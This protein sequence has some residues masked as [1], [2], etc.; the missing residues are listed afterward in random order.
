MRNKEYTEI[1]GKKAQFYIISAVIIIF[2]IISLAVVTNYVTVRKEPTRFYNLADILKTE[3]I[4]VV[5]YSEYNRA[6]GTV[7]EN[8]DR[9]LEIFSAYIETHT[10]EDF[11]LVIL[12]GNASGGEVLGRVIQRT[13]EGGVTVSIGGGAP[14][15]ITQDASIAVTNAT[16]RGDASTGAVNVTI[17]PSAGINITQ[18]VPVLED[19][20]FA[21]VMTT[22][23]GLNQYI[24]TSMNETRKN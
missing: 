20:N 23:Q 10:T 22:S 9:Y 11:S 18:T 5:Q 14:S 7:V 19:N 21:F 1:F 16:V 3:G 24:Q 4:Q 17:T 15:T 12:Y 6:E 2:I 8:I 13:T